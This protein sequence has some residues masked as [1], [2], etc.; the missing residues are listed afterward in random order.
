MELGSYSVL[1]FVCLFFIFHLAAHTEPLSAVQ[2]HLSI[3]PV[4]AHAAIKWL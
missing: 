1:S 2:H 4:A 3:N